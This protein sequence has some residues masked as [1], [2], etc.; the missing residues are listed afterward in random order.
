M[1]SW[2]LQS[3]QSRELAQEAAD[4]ILVPIPEDEKE[5]YEDSCEE[6]NDELAELD[7]YEEPD[8]TLGQKFSDWLDGY[9]R[10]RWPLVHVL[11][12][13]L[14]LVFLIVFEICCWF[15]STFLRGR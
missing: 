2:N 8:K 11:A 5:E 10:N 6:E 4:F 7:D 3:K 13:P 1:D 9:H 15:S 12:F 14:V